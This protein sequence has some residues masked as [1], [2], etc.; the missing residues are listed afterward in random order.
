MQTT[1]ITT[2]GIDTVEVGV[3]SGEVDVATS[4]QNGKASVTVAYSGA[5]D[6]YAVVGSGF[7]TAKTEAQA[8]EAIMAHLAEEVPRD[9]A[10]NA[11]SVS[12][13]GFNA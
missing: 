5:L 2:G 1:T 8:H 4:V 9:A 6:V 12:L 13:Q 3:I 7:P 10:G 11:G